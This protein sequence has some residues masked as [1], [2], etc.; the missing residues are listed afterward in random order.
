M[1]GTTNLIDQFILVS[2]RVKE[3]KQA[4]EKGAIEA[5]VK[6][7]LPKSLAQ[8]AARTPIFCFP[9]SFE[10]IVAKRATENP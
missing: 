9:D 8:S 5:Y 3:G 4:N 1:S 6:Q 7:A 10:E 2:L